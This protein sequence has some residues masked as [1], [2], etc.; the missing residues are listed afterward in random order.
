LLPP[1]FLPP[2]CVSSPPSTFASL[3]LLRQGKRLR[4]AS[5]FDVSPPLALVSFKTETP[6]FPARVRLRTVPPS[7]TFRAFL[8]YR[9]FLFG[10]SSLGI[11]ARS[12]GKMPFVK[13]FSRYSFRS[14]PSSLLLLFLFFGLAPMK[15][16]VLGDG[17][18]EPDRSFDLLSLPPD[19][20]PPCS[21]LLPWR[22]LPLLSKIFSARRELQIKDRSST[23]CT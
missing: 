11:S 18:R 4:S 12:T 7:L 15:S 2:R 3:H 1:L 17:K 20:H 9:A 13:T 21:A 10:F 6:L 23:K 8:L 19:L 14:F 16:S 5:P 22:P